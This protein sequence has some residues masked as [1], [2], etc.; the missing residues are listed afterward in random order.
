MRIIKGMFTLL[1]IMV[2]MVLFVANNPP[3][4]KDFD[5]LWKTVDSLENLRQPRAAME[6][7]DEIYS[8]AKKDENISQI[9]KTQLYR[10]K[11]SSEFEEEYLVKA[12]DRVK[13]EIV[14][15]GKPEQQILH[16]ILGELY[17]KY[18]QNKRYKILNRSAT[19]NLDDDDIQTW[20]AT[21]IMD[22]SKKQYQLSINNPGELQKY[23]IKAFEAIIEKEKKSEAYRPT[24]FDFLAWRAIDFYMNDETD[25]KV[26]SRQFIPDSK[27]YFDSADKFVKIEFPKEFELSNTVMSLQV[28]QDLLKFHLND[29]NPK[30]LIDVDLKRLEFL[31]QKADIADKDEIYLGALNQ[32]KT[33]YKFSEASTAVDF[34]LAK[35]H[36][37]N[38]NKYK[39]L[40]SEDYRWESQKAK[41]ICDEAIKAFPD[42]DGAHNCEIILQGI[43]AKTIT[44]RTENANIPGSPSLGILPWRNIDRLFLRLVK[45]D[46]EDFREL[47]QGTSQKDIAKALA[48]KKFINTWLLK[49][50]D[51]KDYQVHST[52]FQIPA[53]APGFYILLASDDEDFSS[54]KNKL[55]W[56]DF[57]STNLSYIS[58]RLNA[59]GYDLFVLDRQTGEPLKGVHVNVY[60]RDYDY[61]KRTFETQF[62]SGKQSD[63]K[64]FVRIDDID[65]VRGGISIE[66]LKG[67]DKYV[68]DENFYLSKPRERQ[69]KAQDRSFFFTDRAIYR[70]GQL[71][72]FKVIVLEKTGE[73]YEVKPDF[74]T[75]VEFYDA[76]GQLVSSVELSTNDYGSLNGSFT[77]PTGLL[78]GEMRIK[79][80]SGSTS[81]RVEEYKRPKF[82]VNFEPLSG[83]YK[84]GETI[85]LT[86]NAKAYAGNNV[87]GA[88]VK[89]RVVRDSFFPRPYYYF[90]SYWPQAKPI[91][92]ATGEIKTDSDGNFEISFQ[93]IPDKSINQQF[94][95]S[96]SYTISADVTDI[97]G[98]T[99]SGTET[100]N[101]GSEAIVL[102]VAIPENVNIQKPG[103]YEILA[104]NLNGEKQ[105]TTVEIN[106]YKLNQPRGLLKNRFWQQP[107]K[108]II[109]EDEFVKTFPNSVYRDESDPSNWAKG[110]K[111]FEMEINT[112]VDSILPSAIF[113]KWDQGKYMVEMTAVD[114]FGT[115]VK[116]EKIFTLFDQNAKRPPILTYQWFEP[117]KIKGEPGE[118]AQVLLGSS[119]KNVQVLYEFQFKGETL[120]RKWINLS[121]AQELIE[122][123]IKE[124]YRGNINFQYSF[125][126]D[127]RIYSGT[128]I[129]EVPYTNKKLD[130]A[131]ETFRSELEP[132]GKEKW[133]I[134][135]RNKNGDKV[136]AEMLASM[137]DASLDAFLPHTWNFSLYNSF[138]QIN[139]WQANSNFTTSSTG[140]F[141]FD[142]V[143]YKNYIFPQYDRLNWFGLGNYGGYLMRDAMGGMKSRS[144]MQAAPMNEAANEELVVMAD[145]EVPPP[146]P[147][148]QGEISPKEEQSK[149]TETGFQVRRNFNETAFFYPELKTNDSGNVVIEFTLPESFTQWKFMGLGY[150]KDLMTGFLQEE[151]TAAKKLMVVPNAPRFFREGD[152]LWFSTKISNL[153]D[154][155]LD[156]YAQLQLFD[157]VSMKE[158]SAEVLSG[159]TSKRFQADQGKSTTV[160]WQLVI[161]EEYGVLTYRVKASAR[162]FTDGEEKSIPVLPNRM[163]VTEAMPMPVGG[164]ETKEFNFEKLIK[165]GES[166]SLE[167]YRLTLEFA[168]NPAWYAV[169]ALPVASEIKY[170]NAISVFTSFFANSI[171]F[172]ITNQNPEI[173][174][175][176]ENW[177]TETPESFLSKLEK[178]QELKQVLLEQTPWVLNAQNEQERKQ[179]IALLFDLNNMQNRLDNSIR[180]LEK[181]QKP[182]GGFCW[183]DDM[184]ESRYITQMI[185]VGLGKL[186]HLG[187]I[188][189]LGDDRV[190]RMMNSA[191]RFLDSEIHE[192]FEELKKRNPD[193]MDENH[194]SSHH[195]QYLYARSFYKHIMINPSQETAYNYFEHQAET[196]WQKQNNYLQGMIA[197]ALHRNKKDAVPTLIITS[198]KDRALHNDEMGMYWRNDAGYFWYEAPI[199]TQAMMIEVFDEVVSDRESVEEMKMW[200]LKQKQTQD[201]DNDRAT[202]E[203]V[204]ALLGRGNDLLASSDL[205]NITVG[206]E[207][208]G[209]EDM[210]SV[211]AG[212]GYFQTT[213]EASEISPE[214]GSVIVEKTDEGI[215]WG[216]LYWQYFE[217]L[218]KITQHETGLSVQKEIFVE[219]DTEKGRVITPLNDGDVLQLGNKVMVRIEIRVD[220]DMEFV[221]LR[222]MRASAFEPTNVLSGYQYQNGLGYYQ[223]TKD[224]STDFFFDYLRKGTYVFE[225]PLIASQLGDFSN[226]ITTLQ[227]MYAPEFVSHSKGV[228]VR[229]K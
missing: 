156:G 141:D 165:S 124:A 210:G 133:T 2:A 172:H 217:D 46:Y 68:P 40:E 211:E 209:K 218:D 88:L 61:R 180:L 145:G 79:N 48:N 89:Y 64:G 202:I 203:A 27:K 224:A 55:A 18:Y 191:V 94:K 109:S 16:S 90:S 152:T 219:T 76:N 117:L 44:I 105:E 163:M 17:L 115:E 63:D 78:N 9:I 71:V 22:E 143:T 38:A 136:A 179:R 198:L 116:T 15:A 51:D 223:T 69:E 106:I 205:V 113:S 120:E 45:M 187:V 137:Y 171:A 130:L 227:C 53:L 144:D 33:D 34:Q 188:D 47:K 21:K 170:N 96:F 59:G 3:M 35:F 197:L 204:Y 181:Y 104:T 206:S 134:T 107:D 58:Q 26:A 43:L 221:H 57:W 93:A 8:L 169:Q 160:K 54:G 23:N 173:K 164:N 110:D 208:I 155:N 131:F 65:K 122:I 11:L 67:E 146:P 132:G 32:L 82:E 185:V 178:N 95:P 62:V 73:K 85:T 66:L 182:G 84:L 74:M 149:A 28:F 29:K 39:P 201:W 174:R 52:E 226:G 142:P 196:Y 7:V 92:I 214:M 207:S 97:N 194:L 103:N 14:D 222:D 151:F 135:I 186:N 168:S 72:Y 138:N 81:I 50:P 4:E 213:W 129:I 190:K 13:V 162:N 177:Q 140:E 77:I 175:V 118:T 193:K 125:V 20:D 126:I 25:I 148:G 98:E 150:T 49:L 189:A 86:G 166:Q 75:K 102:G 128:Q 119:A 112:L 200:L 12:I 6:V 192:D 153:S 229:V 60:K 176:F 56:A 24:L 87:D 121:N 199:E 42:S 99:Q 220:R 127:N 80:E 91:E 225:Y 10:I 30:A 183:M 195:I 1:L 184:R 101:V 108:F 216:A 100:V 212:T 167:N 37:Q 31:Y 70:P 159:G 111:V 123:P 83:S 158:V 139:A 114:V 154:E 19:M 161:P 5:K 36:H 215:A 147:T 228:R 41:A 157:A